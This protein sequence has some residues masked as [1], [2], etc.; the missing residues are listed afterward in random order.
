MEGYVAAAIALENLNT[1]GRKS[2]GRG[3]HVGGF[4]ISTESDHRR[5]FEQQER[6]AN[7][8]VF[9]KLD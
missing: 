1:T 9:T 2:F 5:V 7:T 6:I 4:G 8:T 3:N